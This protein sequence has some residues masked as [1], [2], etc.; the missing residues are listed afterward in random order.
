MSIDA[1]RHS[2]TRRR[3]EAERKREVASIRALAGLN[4]AALAEVLAAAD[5]MRKAIADDEYWDAQEAA[6]QYDK[7]VLALRA[8]EEKKG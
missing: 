2:A 6:D 5:A 4:P 8:G 1:W 7:A 3:M